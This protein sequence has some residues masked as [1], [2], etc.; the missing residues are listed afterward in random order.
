[1][2]VRD[3]VWRALLG[4][5]VSLVAIALVL[6]SVDTGGTIEVLRTAAP[7]WIALVVAL[8][9][10][11]VLL[12]A[13][14]WQRLLVPIRHVA[15]LPV[16]SYLLVGYLANN[17]LPARLGELVRSHYLGDREGLSR[18]T[19]LGTVVVE[20]VVD[21]A[22]VVAIAAFAILVL[23][24]R[25]VVTSAVLI[26]GA[27]VGLLAIFL[28]IGVAAH[29][30]PGAALVAAWVAQWPRIGQ[31]ASR[32]RGGLAVAGRPRT[33]TEA[34]ILSVAAW[35]ATLLAF[36]AAGQAVGVELRIGEAALLSSGVALASAIPAGPAYL[37]TYELAAVKIAEALGRPPEPAFAIALLVHAAILVVTS[38][39]GL[40]ALS[41]LGWRR[42]SDEPVV[43]APA[44][45]P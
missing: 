15:F 19:T 27:V 12:R 25:G 16:L 24:I 40:V 21:T 39:G 28:G 31:A 36:A 22:V 17:V 41:H 45:E 23:N 11:D 32:L 5:V 3:G 9:S 7:A 43:G 4:T 35:G 6:R 34:L 29:R 13:V 37:G 33:L 8:I 14:R 30:L 1:M 20:R 2:P 38:A 26:G 10:F 18:T 42:S 44:S